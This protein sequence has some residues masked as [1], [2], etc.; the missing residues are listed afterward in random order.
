MQPTS[1]AVSH[2][3]NPGQIEFQRGRLHAEMPDLEDAASVAAHL[4]L[5]DQRLRQME[6]SLQGTAY[7]A[8]LRHRALTENLLAQAK[9]HPWAAFVERLRRLMT[10]YFAGTPRL[11]V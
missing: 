11:G 9:R 10:G 6:A 7:R 1:R 2:S 5:V 3:P 4:A 8:L